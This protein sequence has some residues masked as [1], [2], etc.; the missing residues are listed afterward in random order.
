MDNIDNKAK[1]AESQPNRPKGNFVSRS[2]TSGTLIALLA[3]L[4]L[5]FG[6]L[7]KNFFTFVNL[8]AIVSEIPIFA[9]V[10]VGMT[11][12]ILI[13][14][15]DLSVGS[16][17]GFSVICGVLFSN[18]GLPAW[19]VVI[20]SVI[21]GGVLGFINGLLITKVGV[22]P[23]VT[24]LGMMAAARGADS[25]LALGVPLLKV[26]R[27]YDEKLLG[28][29]RQYIP[30]GA[31]ILPITLIYIVVIYLVAAYVLKYTRFG[32]N[33]YAVG[34]NPYAAKLAGIKVDRIKLLAYVISGAMA[35]FGGM[36]LLAQ[37]GLGRN[38]A[39]TG[40][41][42]Q[43]ITVCLLGGISLAGG[44]GNLFGVLVAVLI[45]TVIENGMVQ[46][47]SVYGISYFWDRVAKGVV[48]L[49][50]ILIDHYRQNVRQKAVRIR[51]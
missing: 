50:A 42:L 33:V 40:V 11:F 27:V 44:R 28:F 9:V 20:A 2:N 23:V 22:N 39:G 38:D 8:K 35:G 32:R 45:I 10:G 46:L 12:V 37:L 26:G 3:I 5:G 48:L 25:W 18:L 1:G 19:V 17:L 51:Q 34:A 15:L 43:V 49:A 36:I 30:A 31:P 13:A 6:L 41:E 29:G 4:V 47:Q 21:V 16:V 24:T 7:T 14:G